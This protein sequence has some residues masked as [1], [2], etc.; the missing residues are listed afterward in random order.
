[1]RSYA[2]V[3]IPVACFSEKNLIGSVVERKRCG[4]S[5]R[6]TIFVI[7]GAYAD[8]H[9]I[10][11]QENKRSVSVPSKNISSATVFEALSLIIATV[12]QLDVMVP[13]EHLNR[14]R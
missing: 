7:L 10:L 3:P 1:M 13:I 8:G 11:K 4:I 14:T 12:V 5:E 9:S 2:L 6:S